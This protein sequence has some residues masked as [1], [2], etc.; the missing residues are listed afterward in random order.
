MSPAKY[1]RWSSYMAMWLPS[2]QC[3]YCPAGSR[4]AIIFMWAGSMVSCWAPMTS[5]G[6]VM[7]AS[8]AVRSQ[9]ARLASLLMPSSLGPCIDT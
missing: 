5:V 2:G 1:T 3:R 6:T 7:V 8:S 4:S 9:P